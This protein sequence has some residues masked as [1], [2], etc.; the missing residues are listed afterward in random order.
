MEITVKVR[1]AMDRDVVFI[2]SK[3]T[4]IDALHEMIRNNVWSI[5]VKKGGL[6]EGVVTE[7]DILRKCILKEFAPELMQVE[8]IMSSPLITIDPEK[9]I[10]EAM[11]LMVEKSIRRVYAIENGKILGRVTQTRAF[12]Y[13]LDALMTLWSIPY[14]L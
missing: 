14:Q 5:V 3:K 10:G 8:E 7:R 12:R 2:D 1:D 4:V 9:P 13:I 6:P 11:K